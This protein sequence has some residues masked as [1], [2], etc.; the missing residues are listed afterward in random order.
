MHHYL[1]EASGGE[2]SDE[3]V[4]VDEVAWVPL[5]ELR[6]RLAYAGERRLVETAAGPARGLGVTPAHAMPVASRGSSRWRSPVLAD[7][8]RRGPAGRPAPTRPAAS[9]RDQLA[10]TP[11]VATRPGDTLHVAGTVTNRGDQALR[12]ASRSGCGCPTPG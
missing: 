8:R 4:E 7:R 2:L 9:D 6:E 5:D 1:L 3:D 10:V 12:D 11:A